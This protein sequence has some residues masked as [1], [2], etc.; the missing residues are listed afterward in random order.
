[1]PHPY[2]RTTYDGPTHVVDELT[3]AALDR[4]AGRL[5][6][7]LSLYQGSYHKGVGP[8]AGTHDGGG[9]VDLAPWDHVDKVRELRRVGFAAWYRPAIAGLWAAHI[10]AVLMGNRKLSPAARA[11]VAEY[12]AGFD[13][14]AGSGRDTGPRR[15]TAHRFDW[16]VGERRLDAAADLIARARAKLATGIRGYR[17]QPALRALRRAQD[18]L[19]EAR[20]E[21]RK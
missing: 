10:H 9:V 15:F 13:G 2:D 19:R 12:L 8:S 16:Q 11:Q 21:A 3:K 20:R 18:Q 14:L 5:D 1:M 7:D 6:Y 4:V 17:V